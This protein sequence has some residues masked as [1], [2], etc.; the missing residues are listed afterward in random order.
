IGRNTA[1][2][3]CQQII[4]LAG[5]VDTPTIWIETYRELAGHFGKDWKYEDNA[6]TAL[7]HISRI[8]KENPGLTTYGAPTLLRPTIELLL[9]TRREAEKDEAIGMIEKEYLSLYHQDPHLYYWRQLKKWDRKYGLSLQV[10]APTYAS[11]ILIY[12][13]RG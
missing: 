3:K 1:V 5:R 8:R 11:P 4:E 13:P 2:Q 12:L 7:G 9:G 10:P 6:R